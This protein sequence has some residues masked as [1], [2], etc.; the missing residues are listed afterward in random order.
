MS[1]NTQAQQSANTQ[2]NANPLWDVILRYCGSNAINAADTYYN[3]VTKDVADSLDKLRQNTIGS[4][5]AG[6]K[7]S[8]AIASA[9]LISSLVEAGSQLASA[10]GSKSMLDEINPAE[11]Q[12]DDARDRLQKLEKKETKLKDN[13]EAQN[14]LNEIRIKKENQKKEIEKKEKTLKT[15]SEKAQIKSNMIQMAGT[16]ASTIPKSV[17]DAQQS[18]GRAIKDVM[19]QLVNMLNSTYQRSNETLKNFFDTDYLGALVTLGNIRIQ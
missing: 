7:A 4:I 10:Y 14:Q 9:L 2:Q 8:F 18:K 16:A 13:P 1:D 3:K 11:K 12:L 19:D 5:A 15:K 6:V 17:S